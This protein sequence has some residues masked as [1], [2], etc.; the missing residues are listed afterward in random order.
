MALY[1][2]GPASVWYILSDVF[3]HLDELNHIS[4]WEQ[5]I[6]SKV[7]HGHAANQVPG[8]NP[9]QGKKGV[10]E[11]QSVTVGDASIARDNG[12]SAWLDLSPGRIVDFQLGVSRS[13]EY[14]LT[15][16]YLCVVLNVGKLITGKVQ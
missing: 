1:G 13:L 16:V 6:Y 12:V 14:D 8:T 15:S 4:P 10:F 7:K 11:N 9:G 5:K 3:H 2:V